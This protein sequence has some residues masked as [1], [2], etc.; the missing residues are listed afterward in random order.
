[1]ARLS[2]VLLFWIAIA[3]IQKFNWDLGVYKAL[4]LLAVLIAVP[5]AAGVAARRGAPDD[6]PVARSLIAAIAVLLTVQVGY[7]VWQLRHPVLTDIAAT[8]LEAGQQL[9]AGT[10]PYAGFYDPSAAGATQQARFAGYKYLPVM[11]GAYLPLGAPLGARGVVLTNLLLQLA[12]V[13]LIFRLG[14]ALAGTTAGALAAL[15]YLSLPLVPFQLFAKGVTDLVPVLP[16]LLALLVLERRPALAGLCI[17]V[18]IS[19]KLMPGML[20]LPC[21]LPATPRAKL[22]Y[23]AGIVLGLLPLLPFLWWA[24]HP[25]IDNIVL[26][27]LVRPAD[28]T[29]WLFAAPA[30]AAALTQ[31]VAVAGFVGVAAQVW[32][33]PPVLAWRIALGA[34]LI[35]AALLAGP[36][37]HHNYQLWWLPLMAALLGAAVAPRRVPTPPPM[38]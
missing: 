5:F 38:V 18:S 2:A 25:F 21:C 24:P 20:L 15:L 34:A 35:L 12:T 32:L 6:G 14:R 17:G 11:I 19:A 36:A 37:A 28:S 4:V 3:L 27:N 33:S 13:A 29:S 30:H 10:N 16:L 8:T 9:L 23:A 26:F 7:A 31:A 1:V 22:S